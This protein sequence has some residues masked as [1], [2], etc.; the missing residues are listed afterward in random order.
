MNKKSPPCKTFHTN[1]TVILQIAVVTFFLA[2][3]PLTA[4]KTKLGPIN[5][6]AINEPAPSWQFFSF[7]KVI[8]Y[9]ID[10]IRIDRKSVV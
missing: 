3:G 2:L 1:L 6:L 5:E 9:Q 4:L 7:V 10:E 8:K